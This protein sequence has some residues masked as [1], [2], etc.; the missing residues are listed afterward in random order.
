MIEKQS[1]K[2]Q[3]DRVEYDHI[4]YSIN[5]EESTA[6]VIGLKENLESFFIPRSIKQES[7]EYDV[8]SILDNAFKDSSIISIQFPSDS[9]LQTIGKNSFS[10]SSI[11]SITIP[12]SVTF[13]G[14]GA[15][16]N[17]KKLQSVVLPDQLV[18]IGCS[19]FRECRSLSSISIPSSVTKI[20]KKAFRYCEE[21]SSVSFV[22]WQ[23]NEFDDYLF[24]NCTKL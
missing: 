16:L 15:F 24:D 18:E 12:S 8:I 4:I 1:S 2:V 17:C 10:N 3:I 9:K 13:I 6:S 5:K 20:H 19:A 23:L 11:K 21:L 14:K 22:N 7:T